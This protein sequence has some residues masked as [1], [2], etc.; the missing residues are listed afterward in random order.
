MASISD[1]FQNDA[2]KQLPM[3]EQLKVA[4]RFPEFSGLPA[5]EQGTVLAKVRGYKDPVDVPEKE[6]GFL[7]TLGTDLKKAFTSVPSASDS[8]VV[9]R[10]KDLGKASKEQ[11][12]KGV[13]A[14]KSGDL[15]S[16]TGRM[17]AAALPGIGPAAAQAG[18]ELGQGEYGKAG[19]HT[20]ELLAPFAVPEVLSAAGTAGRTGKAMVRNAFEN[21]RIVKAVKADHAEASA[22]TPEVIAKPASPPV[23]KPATSE[24]NVP[25]KQTATGAPKKAP[26]SA[27][28]KPTEAKPAVPAKPPFKK[29]GLLERG[30]IIT[31]P[32]A[33]TSG[34]IPGGGP[35][36]GMGMSPNVE[37]FTPPVP[38]PAEPVAAPASKTPGARE[39]RPSDDFYKVHAQV[40]KAINSAGQLYKQGIKAADLMQLSD[41][42][43]KQALGKHSKETY[44]R[45]LFELR[46]L[47]S[48]KVKPIN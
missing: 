43:L 30:S 45:I 34:P 11:F 46:G 35:R 33:D 29:Q 17:A 22:A 42:E 6:A 38:P 1:V 4:R 3:P 18:E 7:E 21:N 31:D 19:A 37:G 48:G 10:A 36:M 12:Q 23:G 15:V 40:K 44:N 14:Y 9:G 27:K 5:K 26:V 20:T 2:F 24:P 28:V 13:A 25:P 41:D 39:P 47:E 32:P 8:A 16:G